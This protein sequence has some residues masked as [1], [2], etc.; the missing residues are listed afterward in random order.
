MTED[1]ARDALDVVIG[2][3]LVNGCRALVLFDSGATSS[4]VSTI[5]SRP[6]VTSPLSETLDVPMS[7]KV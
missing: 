1:E 6:I 2:E 7:V 4:Y 3:Y 5:R